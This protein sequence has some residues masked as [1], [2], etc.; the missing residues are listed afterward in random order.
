MPPVN[1]GGFLINN[2]ENFMNLSKEY[3]ES[4]I[5]IQYIQND[6]GHGIE[7]IRDVIKR[8]F[9]FRNQFIYGIVVL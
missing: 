9:Y 7:H 4:E 5:L 6:P 1:N 2:E 3:I 8:S